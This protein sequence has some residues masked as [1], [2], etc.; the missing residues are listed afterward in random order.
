MRASANV[1][2]DFK[3]LALVTYIYIFFIIHDHKQSEFVVEELT[4]VRIIKNDEL[5]VVD[6]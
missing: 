2:A 1:D 3:M 5:Y 6:L 4:N